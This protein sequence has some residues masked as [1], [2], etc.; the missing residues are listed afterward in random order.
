M[1]VTLQPTALH[2]RVAAIPSKSD[3][4]RV[5]ICAALADR[6]LTFPLPA[7]SADIDATIACLRALGADITV[8]DGTAAVTPI[9]TPA[10]SPTL[11]C[12][13]CGT[14]LRFLLPVAA[15][16]GCDATF[17]GH[18]RLPQRPIGELLDVL[19]RHG[20]HADAPALP[21]TLHGQLTPGEFALPGNVS[22]QYV[23]GLLLALPRLGGGSRIR[24]TTPPESTGYIDMTRRTMARFGVAVA[25][26]AD[27]FSFD[28][29][30][31]YR[32]PAS[33]AIDGDWSNAAFWLAAGALSGPITV[34]GLSADSAQG[35]RAILTL[36]RRF[37]AQ[38]QRQGDA[39]TVSPAPLHGIEI[40]M[41]DIPDLL[42]PLAVIA[43]GAAGTTRLYNAARVRLKECDRLRGMAALLTA[44]GGRAEERE[45]ELLIHGGTPLAGGT[46]DGCND[47]RLV[48][49][50]ALAATLAAA[51]VAVSDGEAVAKSYP[52]FFTDYQQLGGIAHGVP[53]W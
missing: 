47:H 40:D 51:P 46:A 2:G 15:A 10:A 49:A 16:L 21:L 45:D 11:D 20:V 52:A 17:R 37:G 36:L 41:R 29:D 18:G 7:R 19:A 24:L 31:V 35:D 44:L 23:S 27:G 1:T 32:A 12:G 50:A 34:T 25:D 48:M 6:P 38:V 14:T 3:A 42:P 8:R 39:V 30:A 53:V 28:G 13:E 4:H 22:S 5:L 9:S 43:A 26:E 33:A